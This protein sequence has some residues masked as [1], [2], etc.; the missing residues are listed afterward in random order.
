M[1]N[2]ADEGNP[3]P[4]TSGP[5][6]VDDFGDIT[7]LDESPQLR[8][9]NR[10]RARDKVRARMAFTLLGFLGVVLL[11]TLGAAIYRPSAYDATKDILTIVV[12][13]VS[14]VVG[15]YFGTHDAD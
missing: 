6:D 3:D 13:L 7:N 15:F 1:G 9:Y 5:D 10:R 8:P 4:H 11:V 12:G 14:A 2:P